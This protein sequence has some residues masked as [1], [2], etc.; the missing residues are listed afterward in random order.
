MHPP[1]S[2][3]CYTIGQYLDLVFP[4][5]Y[6]LLERNYDG[7]LKYSIINNRPGQ[8]RILLDFKQC[9]DPDLVTLAAERGHKECLQLLLD[10]KCPMDETAIK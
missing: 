8:L 2:N 6:D 9:T 1:P 10:A 7:L 5:D 3:L 4:T